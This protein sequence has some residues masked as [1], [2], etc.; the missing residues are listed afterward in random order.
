MFNQLDKFDYAS[1][2]LTEEFVLFCLMTN[3]MNSCEKSY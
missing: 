3:R 2:P 1:V